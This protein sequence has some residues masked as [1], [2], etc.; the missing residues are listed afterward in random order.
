MKCR[1]ILAKMIIAHELSFSFVKYQWFNILMKY[2]NHFYQKM[3]RV[4]IRKDCTKVF[5][6]EKEKMRKIQTH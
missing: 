3:S 5:E 6:V 2:N 4:I 1:E